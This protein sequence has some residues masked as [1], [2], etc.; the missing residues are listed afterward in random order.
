MKP[1]PTVLHDPTA[2]TSPVVRP[3]LAPPDSL[4]GKV[5]ALQGIGKDLADK[6]A[7]NAV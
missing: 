6:C 3:R 4:Q 2:E 7:P 5:V 1:T